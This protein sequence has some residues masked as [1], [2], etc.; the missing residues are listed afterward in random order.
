MQKSF[1]RPSSSGNKAAQPY[2]VVSM[3]QSR[4]I[5]RLIARYRITNANGDEGARAGGC[6]RRERIDR[7]HYPTRDVTESSIIDAC[8]ISLFLFIF[9][10]LLIFAHVSRSRGTYSCVPIA[11]IHNLGVTPSTHCE[12]WGA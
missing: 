12:Q 9:F 5:T 8:A 10:I 2:R 3:L 6:V 7:K 4:D 11:L 1:R